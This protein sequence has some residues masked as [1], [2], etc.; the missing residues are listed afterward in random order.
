MS[1]IANKYKPWIKY[2]EKFLAWHKVETLLVRHLNNKKQTFIGLYIY[3]FIVDDFFNCGEQNYLR[4]QETSGHCRHCGRL[5]ISGCLHP[6]NKLEWRKNSDVLY[7]TG[8]SRLDYWGTVL[9]AVVCCGSGLEVTS[10]SRWNR[11]I[12]QWLCR[13]EAGLSGG[14]DCSQSFRSS[15]QG[16]PPIVRQSSTFSTRL[17]PPQCTTERCRKSFLPAIIKL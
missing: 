11:L 14:G 15:W 6:D 2:G 1:Q 10:V 16:G 9:F 17:T 8:Q 5:Q 7:R 4:L 12:C 3:L 13:D